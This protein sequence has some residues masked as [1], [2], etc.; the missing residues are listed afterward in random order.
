LGKTHWTYV[1]ALPV[2][3]FE[4]ASQDLLR[5]SALAVALGFLLALAATLL[6]MRPITS[7]L[8]RLTAA[9]RGLAR[10]DTQ[11]EL[12]LVGHDEIGQMADAFRDVMVYQ[13]A[14]AEV[15]DGVVAGA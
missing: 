13:G 14:M 5:T 12:D 8:R 6:L 3:V 9:A 11:Q 4:A 2:S 1:A 10:G 15:A 7:G